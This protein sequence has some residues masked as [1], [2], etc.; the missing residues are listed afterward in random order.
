MTPP[1]ANTSKLRK[2]CRIY[3]TQYN[4]K[5]FLPSLVV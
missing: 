3:Y 2:G 4:A 5:A 1:I